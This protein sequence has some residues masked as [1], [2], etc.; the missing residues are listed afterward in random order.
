MRWQ[1]R[2]LLLGG[3][4]AALALLVPEETFA[5]GG[6]GRRGG[7]RGKKGKG[8]EVL[9]RKGLVHESEDE[10]RNADRDLRLLTG[11]RGHLDAVLAERRQEV[12]V[13]NRHRGEDARRDQDARREVSR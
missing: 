10:M 2:I 6:G 5:R 3:A 12:L 4:L 9:D 11:R 8:G 1:R 7:G 13:R